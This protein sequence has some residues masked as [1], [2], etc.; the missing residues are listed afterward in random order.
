[1]FGRKKKIPT[2]EEIALENPPTPVIEAVAEKKT[3]KPRDMF[4]EA[5]DYFENNYL[6]ALGPSFTAEGEVVE[7]KLSL[8]L[9]YAIYCELYKANNR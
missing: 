8:N 2:K 3:E 7:D 6:N 4:R 9:L 5:S 1:M